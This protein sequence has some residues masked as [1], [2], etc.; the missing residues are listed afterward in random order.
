MM[1]ARENSRGEAGNDKD[2]GREENDDDCR[3]YNQRGPVSLELRRQN[4]RGTRLFLSLRG[5]IIFRNQTIFV[6]PEI[7]GNRADETAIEDPAGKLV[8][9]VVFQ[10]FEEFALNASGGGDLFEGNAAQ[11]AFSFQ[12]FAEECGGHSEELRRAEKI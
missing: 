12:T 6:E 7:L 11:L 10:G 4:G 9:L 1:Q 3:G 5:K 2:A 8:P